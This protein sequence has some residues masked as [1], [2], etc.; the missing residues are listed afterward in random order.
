MTDKVL[1]ETLEQFLTILIG[2]CGVRIKNV[3]RKGY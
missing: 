2:I 3:D 1:K